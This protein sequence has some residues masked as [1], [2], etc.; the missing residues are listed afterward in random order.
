L[1]A[2]VVSVVDRTAAGQVARQHAALLGAGGEVE[3]VPTRRSDRTGSGLVGRSDGA[4]LLVLGAGDPI[5][6]VMARASLPVLVARGT[7]HGTSLTDRIL[8][9]IDAGSASDHAADL[10]GRIAS[11]HN[12][13]VAVV[14]VPEPDRGLERATSASRRIITQLAGHAPQVSGGPVRAE[15]AI[16]SAV[17]ASDASLLVLP[18]GSTPETR[19]RA[20][21]VARL[22]GCSVLAVPAPP[23]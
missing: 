19:R 10:A 6:G 13:A 3:H 7:T 2:R 15:R 17:A 8:V 23:G 5:D 11:R 20:A 4:D 14:A 16:L 18:L 22:V 9:A 1:F 21:Q 12:S